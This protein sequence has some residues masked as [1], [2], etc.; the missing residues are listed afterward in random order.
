MFVYIGVCALINTLGKLWLRLLYIQVFKILSNGNSEFPLV[1]SSAFI[2]GSIKSAVLC[3]TMV[4]VAKCNMG[5]M[6]VSL[7]NL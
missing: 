4:I 6:F 1:S 2:M 5:E 7:M 3:A